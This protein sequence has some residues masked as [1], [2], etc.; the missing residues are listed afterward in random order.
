MP[1]YAYQSVAP[2]V[3]VPNVAGRPMPVYIAPPAAIHQQPQPH[4]QQTSIVNGVGT[5]QPQPPPTPPA[6]LQISEDDMKL[7]QEMF[8]NIDREVIKSVF[9]AN[10]GNKDTTIN[11]LLQMTEQ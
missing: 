1:A 10:R 7:V 9:E 3:M 2:V 4:P 6:P 5:P 8:P 11:S